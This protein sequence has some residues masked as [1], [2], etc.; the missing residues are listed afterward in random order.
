MSEAGG[1]SITNIAV[2]SASEDDGRPTSAKSEA[3]SAGSEAVYSRARVL[4]LVRVFLSFGSCLFVLAVA[5]KTTSLMMHEVANLLS[6]DD[7]PEPL[8]PGY[9]ARHWVSDHPV[10]VKSSLV[11]S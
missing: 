10:P 9:P 2:I 6:Y 8:P 3:D 4:L 11:V 1:A 7:G 5:V